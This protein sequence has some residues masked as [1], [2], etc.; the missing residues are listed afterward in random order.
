MCKKLHLLHLILDSYRQW[1]IINSRGLSSH[2]TQDQKC[3]VS[4]H[5][6]S[7]GNLDVNMS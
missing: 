2:I 5:N 7:K 1:Q 4:C 6:T 3:Q